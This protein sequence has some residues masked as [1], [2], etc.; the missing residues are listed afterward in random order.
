MSVSGYQFPDNTEDYY[1]SNW[2]MISV[3]ATLNERSW[4]FLDPSMLT[5]EL[6][7]LADWFDAHGRGGGAPATLEFI[8]PNLSLAYDDESALRVYFELEARP[9]WKRNSYA[10]QGDIYAEFRL[11]REELKSAATRARAML[12]AYPQRGKR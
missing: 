11:K 9:P 10:G 8:E 2:L 5:F 6:A 7:A 4:S 1:D 3:Q 12:G